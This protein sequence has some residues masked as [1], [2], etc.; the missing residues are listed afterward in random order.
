MAAA[1]RVLESARNRKFGR[2]RND[3]SLVSYRECRG[4]ERLLEQMSFWPRHFR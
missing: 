1:D 4:A 3:K 2:I